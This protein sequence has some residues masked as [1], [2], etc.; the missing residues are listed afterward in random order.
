[1]KEAG[2]AFDEN[3][4]A[5]LIAN[6]WIP[7][8]AD[9]CLYIKHFPGE[10]FEWGFTL[11]HVDDGLT[12]GP[13]AALDDRTMVMKQKFKIKDVTHK[14]MFLGMEINREPNNGAIHLTQSYISEMVN[15][16]GIKEVAATTPMTTTFNPEA[17]DD[18]AQEL[19]DAER[20][21]YKSMVGGLHYMSMT[22]PDVGYAVNL[23]SRYL[24]NPTNLLMDAA[25][26]VLSYLNRTKLLGIRYATDVPIVPVGW[27][28][29]AF[30]DDRATG[31]STGGYTI[32]LKGSGPIMSATKRIK[33]VSL[34]SCEAELKLLTETTQRTCWLRNILEEMHLLPR[35]PTLIWEDNTGVIDIVSTPNSMNAR[36]AHIALRE[37]FCKEKLQDKTIT[38]QYC[39]SAKMV[40]DIMTK[41]LAME[42]YEYLRTGL[43]TGMLSG[44]E[45]SSQDIA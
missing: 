41:A 30:N 31:R 16:H 11:T 23:L 27:S 7:C 9:P 15:M 44:E 21:K 29:S 42:K 8:K 19:T 22:R 43:L 10:A 37:F 18:S 32:G 17:K 26:R 6:G 3:Q 20:D 45:P 12:I 24:Q 5:L 28:D 13:Q 1:M 34:S 35:G 33:T 40:A 36:T 14:Q 39:R 2:H 25:D 38:V 4:R